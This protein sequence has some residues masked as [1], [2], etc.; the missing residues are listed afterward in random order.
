MSCINVDDCV[1]SEVLLVIKKAVCRGGRCRR[2][3]REESTPLEGSKADNFNFCDSTLG[4]FVK[5]RTASGG[6]AIGVQDF[7]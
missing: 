6:R 1:T 3:C 7:K 4:E 2:L 5:G